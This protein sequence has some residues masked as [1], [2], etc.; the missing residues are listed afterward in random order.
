MSVLYK[1]IKK[2]TNFKKN[3]FKMQEMSI[4]YILFPSERIACIDRFLISKNFAFKTEQNLG[5]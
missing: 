3:I 5:F 4:A 2:Y 1:F